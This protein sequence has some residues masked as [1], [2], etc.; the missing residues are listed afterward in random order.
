M[1]K[2]HKFLSETEKKVPKLY[3]NIL[4]KGQNTL[5]G[6]S[7]TR[8]GLHYMIP[9]ITYARSRLL[10]ILATHLVRLPLDKEIHVDLDKTVNDWGNKI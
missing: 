1:C 9:I 7:K 5:P 3:P 6:V 4:K 2:R 10:S 8:K